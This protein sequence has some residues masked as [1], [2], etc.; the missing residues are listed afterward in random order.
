[1]KHYIYIIHIIYHTIFHT[2]YKYY[3]LL[4]PWH[5]WGEQKVQRLALKQNPLIYDC[6]PS[7]A[8]C[9]SDCFSACKTTQELPVTQLA[10][11]VDPFHLLITDNQRPETLS[12]PH[13]LA[14]PI[15]PTTHFQPSCSTLNLKRVTALRSG[16]NKS[17]FSTS[18]K[19]RRG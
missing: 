13:G 15:K 14:P 3:Q 19:P 1:M 8:A 11:H 7:P 6:L 5:S 2:M 18:G 10:R 4:G 12:F 17:F 16:P 9:F